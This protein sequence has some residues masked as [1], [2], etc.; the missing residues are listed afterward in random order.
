MPAQTITAATAAYASNAPVYGGLV[1]HLYRPGATP[2][3]LGQAIL[4]SASPSESS[5]KGERTNELGGENGWWL[6]DGPVEGSATIQVKDASSP[7]IH[8]GDYFDAGIR[9]DATGAST[10]ER[11]V[12]FNPGITVDQGGA[13][14]MT[15]SIKLDRFATLS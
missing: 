12:I 7:T 8:T 2:T 3:D 11:F 15:C 9:H 13:R 6:V 1:I 14:K 10:T 4:E 5:V